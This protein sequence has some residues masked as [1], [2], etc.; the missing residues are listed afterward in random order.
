MY[1]SVYQREKHALRVSLV[2][3]TV[4]KVMQAGL[5]LVVRVKEKPDA[6]ASGFFC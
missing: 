3:A 2:I 6:F 1:H 4:V 5:W